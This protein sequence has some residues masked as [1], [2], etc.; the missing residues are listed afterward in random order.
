MVLAFCQWLEHTPLAIFVREASYAFQLIAG[1]HVLG[2]AFSVG[3][4]IWFDLRLLGVSLLAGRISDVYRR[5]IP[6]ATVGFVSMFVTGAL[7]FSGYA[8][9]AYASV[10][11]RIKVS[12]IVL[13][14][15]NALFYHLVTERQ[16]DQSDAHQSPAAAV[17]LAGGA[18]IFLWAI[19][20]LCGRMISYTIF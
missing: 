17:R 5:L 7:L 9:A 20:I 19:V 6:W 3:M 11:F 15:A 4:L 1:V 10:Y 13:A 16:L 14:G 12:A 18:S 8:T 2:L